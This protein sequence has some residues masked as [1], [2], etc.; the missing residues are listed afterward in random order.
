MLYYSGFRVSELV[1]LRWLQFTSKS[2]GTQITVKG[3]GGR[4]RTVMIRNDV[5]AELRNICYNM[6]DEYVF[7]S[8][9]R[10][11]THL[12]VRQV[13]TIVAAESKNAGFPINPH[14]FRHG[15]ASHSLKNGAD[16]KLIQDNL[17]HRSIATTEIYLQVDPEDSSG[18]Y[19]D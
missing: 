9:R 1:G 7:R 13:E 16:L 2:Q 19:L 6:E 5:Y 15:H 3:K 12:S 18:L 17:G 14:K 8:I 4:V 10:K 11:G